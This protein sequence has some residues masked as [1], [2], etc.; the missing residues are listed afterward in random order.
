[1]DEVPGIYVIECVP[2]GRVY[3]GSSVKPLARIKSHKNLLSKGTHRNVHLQRAWGLHGSNSFTFTVVQQCVAEERFKVEQEWITKLQAT[4]KNG[5]NIAFPV[6]QVLPSERM[7]QVSRTSWKD[8]KTRKNRHAGIL[9]KWQDDAFRER[10]LRDGLKARE[11]LAKKRLDPEWR[12]RISEKTSKTMKERAK[13]EEGLK[14]LRV[15]SKI[16]H[17]RRENDP[18]FKAKCEAGLKYSSTNKEIVRPAANKE[19]AEVMD[20]EPSR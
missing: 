13:T 4:G 12:A 10:K 15:A 20:K 9:T 5:F 8:K 2:T 19:A 16:A 14:A 3:V 1:M 6:E 11:A 18:E 17:M 7:S